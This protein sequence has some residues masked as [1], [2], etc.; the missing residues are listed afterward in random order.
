MAKSMNGKDSVKIF[1]IK[2]KSM[3][4][5]E[6]PM[7]EEEEDETEMEGDPSGMLREAADMIEE[8]DIEGA[9]EIIDQ[10]VELCK[11]MH[12]SDSEEEYD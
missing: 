9:Y 12:G 2:A 11:E 8:G 5:P 10:A 1:R 3:K 6:K 4:L 7:M